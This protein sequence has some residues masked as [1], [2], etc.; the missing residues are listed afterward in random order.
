MNVFSHGICWWNSIC[1][2]PS[3][4][5]WTFSQ[6]VQIMY[7]CKSELI[8]WPVV[9]NCMNCGIPFNSLL[10]HMYHIIV[11]AIVNREYSLFLVLTI[12]IHSWMHTFKLLLISDIRRVVGE[13]KP[14]RSSKLAVE[15][16]MLIWGLVGIQNQLR[17]AL[18]DS[19]FLRHR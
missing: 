16:E 19:F 7:M 2:I 12:T 9:G 4:A 8:E 18:C 5:L 13:E 15:E 3:R 1:G 17:M 14:H 6:L 11:A 10:F